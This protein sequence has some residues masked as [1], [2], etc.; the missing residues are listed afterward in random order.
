MEQQEVDND[1]DREENNMNNFTDDY[2]DG[3]F[4]GDEVDNYDDYNS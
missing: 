3:N 2:R 1:I 4:D